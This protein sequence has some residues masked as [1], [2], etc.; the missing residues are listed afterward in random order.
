M[1]LDTILVAV[2]SERALATT[3]AERTAEVAA[4]ADADV[5]L[6]HVY[7]DDEYDD[8]RDRLH[9]APDSEVTPDEIAER[10][11]SA[12]EART[13]LEDAGL[14]VSTYG[15]VSE[16]GSKGRRLVAMADEFDAD[17][18]I[19]GGRDRTPV[20]KAVFGSTAQKVML[21]A[22]CPVLFVRNE[23]APS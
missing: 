4:P 5:L 9:V 11:A 15:R 23:S 16:T 1:S 20:G 18:L 13:V 19:I 7:T 8:T 14:D 21:E 22:P 10:N 3:L 12:R 2:S 6:A 17:M